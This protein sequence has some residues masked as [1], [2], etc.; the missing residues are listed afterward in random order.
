VISSEKSRIAA[1]HN[2]DSKGKSDMKK[3]KS[4][5]NDT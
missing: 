3:K 2:A 4:K 5:F 1:L